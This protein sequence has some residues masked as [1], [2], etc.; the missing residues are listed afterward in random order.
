MPDAGGCG[1][2]ELF[3]FDR[4]I[5]RQSRAPGRN[6]SMEGVLRDDPD[7]LLFVEGCEGIGVWRICLSMFVVS[8]VFSVPSN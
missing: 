4:G 2:F 7:W 3:E 6:F 1:C 5:S 8:G